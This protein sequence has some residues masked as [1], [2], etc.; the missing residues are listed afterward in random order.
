[1]HPIAP[2]TET[3]ISSYVGK[4]VCAVLHDGTYIYGTVLECRNGHLY[5]SQ[6][7][8]G[9]GPV[10]TSANK[11]KAQLQKKMKNKA[12]ISFFGF[13]AAAAAISLAFIVALFAFP[14]GFGYG[15]GY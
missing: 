8:P 4:P 1:M 5:F 3:S 2:I 11:P 13:G 9:T 14:F 15:Y 10:F 12:T 6:I 7:N